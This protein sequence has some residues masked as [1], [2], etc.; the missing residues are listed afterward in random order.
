MLKDAVVVVEQKMEKAF[1]M[2][3]F[4]M[5]AEDVRIGEIVGLWWSGM[6]ADRGRAGDVLCRL[7]ERFRIWESG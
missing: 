5:I 4:R 6:F 3:P 1:S 7:R 2:Q